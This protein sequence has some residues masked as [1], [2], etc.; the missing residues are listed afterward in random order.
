M[1]AIITDQFRILNAE[2][3][4]GSFS[5]A[6]TTSY[7]YSFLGHPNPT[8]TSIEYG[9]TDWQTNPPDPKDSFEQE[10]SYHNSMLFMKRITSDDVRMIIPRFN[11][12]SGSIYDRYRHNIDNTNPSTSLDAKTL[13][14][15][16][17]IVVN[18]EYKV[19]L[20]INNGE[21]PEN[22]N[23]QKSTAEPNFATITPQKAT[24]NATDGYIWK[25]L[26]TI[27]PADV[28]KFATEKY[29]PLPKDWGTGSTADVFNA[30]VDGKLEKNAI[31]IKNRG[32]GYQFS[33][34]TQAT[35]P[36]YGDGYGGRASI[37]INS[38]NQVESAEIVDGGVG[39]TKAFVIF[40][41]VGETDIGT[42][43]GTALNHV[44]PNDTSTAK[45][46]IDKGSGA[47]FE[48]ACPPKGG[49][50]SDINREC[51]S[52][53]VMVYSKY[54][55]DPDYVTGNNFSRIG[56][57]KNPTVYNSPTEL[58]NRSTATSTFAM[59]LQ[60]PA[61]GEDELNYP[62]NS[63]ITQVVGYNPVTGISSVAVGYVASFDRST[64]ILKYYQPVGLS[65]LNA[66][67]YK[68]LPFNVNTGDSDVTANIVC[69]GTG[70]VAG[71]LDA[72]FGSTTDGFSDGRNSITLS[73]GK[74]VQLGQTFKNG[75]AP[76]EVE[77]YSGDIIYID[78][79]QSITRSAAQKEELK[80]V[81]EF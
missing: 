26:F 23:G 4:V 32:S 57:V 29:I 72:N 34:G 79:R 64:H 61:S 76:P 1:P 42:T 8:N 78:N 3:F 65:T 52:H 74:Y 19:Y 18:S 11:W 39:Y 77:R 31:T 25:Y 17:Y 68:I 51:G 70:A 75:I 71:L 12:Q 60:V 67:G 50:G 36:I 66:S 58:I 63:K 44:N 13:Y 54:D 24:T 55:S 45:V 10:S 37:T 53:R 30:A 40:Q 20:C 5:G 80:I 22:K 35:L 21:D 16:K 48:I 69:D 47:E 28:I 46:T 59:K 14:E 41:G 15:S 27:S 2:T 9:K 33:S 43:Y 81:V 6:G 7:Y 73:T 56:I 62:I 38:D 49:H